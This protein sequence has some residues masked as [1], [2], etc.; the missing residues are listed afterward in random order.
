MPRLQHRLMRPRALLALIGG[1]TVLAIVTTVLAFAVG[2]SPAGGLFSGLGAPTGQRITMDQAQHDLQTAVNQTGNADLRLDEILEFT[3]NFYAIVKEKSTGMG[4]FELLVDPSSGAV[5]P[6]YGPNMMWNAKYGMMGGWGPAQ[7]TVS[8]SQATEIAHRWL[9]Q[10]QPGSTTE[11]PDTFYGY[12]TLHIL[13]GGKITGML[14]VNGASGQVWYHS[15]H[16]AF[17]RMRELGQ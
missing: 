4:A 3:G 16:G 7:M 12:Y 11:A 6:E 13:K 2:G 10:N 5:F 15:W 14:S 8:A 17:I 1:L 9:E